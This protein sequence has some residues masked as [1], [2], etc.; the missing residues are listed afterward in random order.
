MWQ[1][2]S[3]YRAVPSGLPSSARCKIKAPPLVSPVSA[4]SDPY[5]HDAFSIYSQALGPMSSC[6]LRPGRP[7]AVSAPALL[8]YRGRQGR[9]WFKDEAPEAQNSAGA[10]RAASL[11]K[12]GAVR[13]PGS[14]SEMQDWGPSQT[15]RIRIYMSA[16]DPQRICVQICVRFLSCLLR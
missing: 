14:L 6:G 11:L 2:S 9:N 7:Q 10:L 3:E 12:T 1:L 15:S 8:T 13:S 16:K 4:D 5:S